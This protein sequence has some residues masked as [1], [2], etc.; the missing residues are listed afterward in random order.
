MS[1]NQPLDTVYLIS[2]GTCLQHTPNKKVPVT[3][4][5]GCVELSADGGKAAAHAP[6]LLGP[7]EPL[8]ATGPTGALLLFQ[9]GCGSAHSYLWP[10]S[11]LIGTK[12]CLLQ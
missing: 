7:T 3:A 11:S 4:V 1:F 8:G 5:V 10:V 9:N 6:V 12:P 2:L